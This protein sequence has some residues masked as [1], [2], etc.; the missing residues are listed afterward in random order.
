MTERKNERSISQTEEMIERRKNKTK[1]RMS[2]DQQ[3]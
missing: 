1:D 3:N 2:Y